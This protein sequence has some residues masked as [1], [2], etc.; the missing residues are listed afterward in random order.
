MA[1]RITGGEHSHVGQTMGDIAASA[2][3]NAHFGKK[4]WTALEDQY[5]AVRIRLRACNRSKEPG[6]TA[7]GDCN[8]FV[9]HQINLTR[10]RTNIAQ[11]EGRACLPRR[12]FTRRRFSSLK[13]SFGSER[14]TRRAPPSAFF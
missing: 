1:A 11:S 13:L 4:L 10:Y 3:G 14:W 9:S 12:S 8:L 5:L 7:A 2:A 6:C